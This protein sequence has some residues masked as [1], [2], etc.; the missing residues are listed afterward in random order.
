MV[1]MKALEMDFELTKSHSEFRLGI[2]AY[3]LRKP[4][5]SWLPRL[6]GRRGYVIGSQAWNNNVA[7]SMT[8]CSLRQN[9]RVIITPSPEPYRSS[10]QFD[11]IQTNLD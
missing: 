2:F 3:H 11:K 7:S 4:L 5:R 1:Q 8:G 9:P 6:N 10:Q